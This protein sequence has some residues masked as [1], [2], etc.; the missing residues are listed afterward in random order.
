MPL[1]ANAETRAAVRRVFAYAFMPRRRWRGYFYPDTT[2]VDG[3]FEIGDL[4]ITPIPLRHGRMTTLGYLFCQQG[5]PKLA[6][7]TDCQEVPETAF[8]QLE[9]VPALVLEALRKR[10]HPTHMS[11]DEAL[12]ASRRIRAGQ[13]WLTHLTHDYDHDVDQAELPPTAGL[14]Y[15]GLQ[16]ILP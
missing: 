14:A 5:K 4:E 1:Y 6:Y 11:L 15:D 10:P 8:P 12:A 3:P 2:L 7:L 16:V 13:T 9:G